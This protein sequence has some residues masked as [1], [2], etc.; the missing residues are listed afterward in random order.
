MAK[1]KKADRFV[2]VKV[3]LRPEVLEQLKRAADDRQWSFNAEITKRLENSF[4]FDAQAA[5]REMAWAW[6]R[7]AQRLERV[8]LEALRSG[9]IDD[10]IYED[11]DEDDPFG[12]IHVEHRA[13]YMDEPGDLEATIR[14]R[15]QR[16][17]NVPPEYGPPIK[18]E[19]TIKGEK[20]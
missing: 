16:E 10:L 13:V 5:M 6:K 1:K 11:L 7:Q 17:K 4:E 2:Q 9:N 20:K 8:R 12:G 18:G 3:R 15:R 19:K 14:K